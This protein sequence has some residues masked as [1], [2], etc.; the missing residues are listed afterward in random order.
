M[1][2]R[3]EYQ[4]DPGSIAKRLKNDLERGREMF[5]GAAQ[6]SRDV[7]CWQV[8]LL[9]RPLKSIIEL[10]TGSGTF[11]KWLRDKA[12]N[13]LTFD[14]K[15]P[16]HDIE[17]FILADIFNEEKM[18]AELIESAKR[19]LLFYC[20]NGDKAR[21]VATFSKY[22]HKGDYLGT[23]DFHIEIHP[24]DIPEDFELIVNIGLTAF[25]KKK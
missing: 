25:W 8:F 24:Q 17:E 4:H 12:P 19:P 21:E 2:E 11:S 23:H 3:M 6:D 15:K 18:I 22:L 10:G 20:D 7:F 5:K 13:F 14:N 16:Y 9:E 1:E